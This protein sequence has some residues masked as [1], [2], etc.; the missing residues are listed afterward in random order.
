MDDSDVEDPKAYGYSVFAVSETITVSYKLCSGK[1]TTTTKMLLEAKEVVSC[2]YLIQAKRS[3]VLVESSEEADEVADAVSKNVSV[4][5]PLQTVYK[6]FPG[7]RCMIKKWD[8]ELAEAQ[9]ILLSSLPLVVLPLV[10]RYPSKGENQGRLRHGVL[11]GSC[12]SAPKVCP[13]L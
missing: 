5:L 11:W 2:P 13:G 3:P 7:L 1:S 8:K 9:D 6:E 4:L 10:W 12:P